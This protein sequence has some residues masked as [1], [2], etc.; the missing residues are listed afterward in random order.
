MPVFNLTLPMAVKAIIERY[1]VDLM[2]PGDVYIT[3]DPWLCAGHLFDLAIVT[4]VFHRDRVVAL[5]G[6][7]HAGDIGGSRDGL[8]V[9]ELYEEGIQIPAMKLVRE[10]VE[11][12]DLFRLMADN[13]RD[14][15][16]VLGDVRSFISANETGSAR[17][18]S[19]MEEY[20]MHDL[21]GVVACRAVAVRKYARC[22]HQA[23]GRHLPFGNFNNPIL[24]MTF[25]LT[26]TVKGDE[27]ELD[28]EGAPPQTVKGGINCTLSY[29]TA[30]ATYPIKCMLTPGIRGNAGCYRPFTVKAPKG[31]ILNCEKAGAGLT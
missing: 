1:P 4:P 20:G 13:I 14:S 6:R 17:M 29:T 12:E 23:H 5:M 3:N 15:D 19:F 16:Q 9:T 22:R 30:H 7:R 26:V 21:E 18:R 10:G 11:N 28:F 2:K 8:N 27:I 24:T 31:S 25:P